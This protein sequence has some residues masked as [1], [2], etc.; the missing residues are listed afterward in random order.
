M[1]LVGDYH[2]HSNNSRFKLSKSSVEDIIKRANMVGLYE[3]AITDHGY[4]HFYAA[5]KQKLLQSREIIKEL[6]D[7]LNI[8]VMLW[9][10]ADIISKDGTLD[11]DQ[12]TLDNI[13]LL[14]IG[15]HKMIK[16]DFASYFG[17]QKNTNGS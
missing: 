13:D 17:R 11:V 9:I 7:S 15:Y 4:N 3:I 5:N 8:R 2:I 14:T 16:T 6:S 12:E 10:E 1:K